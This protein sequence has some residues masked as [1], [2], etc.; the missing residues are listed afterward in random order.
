MGLNHIKIL[1]VD[2]SSVMRKMIKHE[3]AKLGVQ[4]DDAADGELAWT[5]LVQ[6]PEEFKVVLSDVNMPNLNGIELLRRIRGDERFKELPVV[7]LTSETDHEIVTA[8]R[9][10]GVSAYLNKPLQTAEL[11]KVLARMMVKAAAL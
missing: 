7:M 5:R 3:L 2:D 10:L 11:V 9:A 6:S 4:F 8:A 1:V